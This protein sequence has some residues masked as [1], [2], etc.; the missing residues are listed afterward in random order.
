MFNKYEELNEYLKDICDYLQKKNPYLLNNISKI[1]KLGG[2]A[3]KQLHDFDFATDMKENGL[4]VENVER[5]ARSIIEKINKNY[6]VLFDELV[7]S[8][9]LWYSDNNEFYDTCVETRFEDDGSVRK[10]ILINKKHNY[11]DVRILIHEF[12]HYTTCERCSINREILSEFLAIYFEF[13]AVDYL[14][15]R[16]I[17]LDEIDYKARM[18]NFKEHQINLSNYGII[19]FIYFKSGELDDESYGLVKEHFP[20]VS[21]EQYVRICDKF[22]KILTDIEENYCEFIEKNPDKKGYYLCRDFILIDYKY[23]LGT[24]LAVYC[25]KYSSLQDVVD[26]NDNISIWDSLTMEEILKK[27]G[28][29]LYDTDFV[30]KMKEAFKEYINNL[31]KYNN[32]NDETLGLRKK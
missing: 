10:R 17:S 9:E 25:Y 2:T 12:I 19:L 29:D 28:I 1:I 22:Y 8:D 5:I 18:Q 14:L 32:K 30:N 24:I 11:S 4:S 16:G 26:L 7:M 20:K 27:L 13:Y 31:N 23:V 15:N 21:Y 6:L 3:L